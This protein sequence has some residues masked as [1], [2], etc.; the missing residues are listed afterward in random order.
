MFR[1][2][3]TIT[4]KYPVALVGAGPGSPDLLT[5]RAVETLRQ[6][7]LVIYDRLVPDQLL[8]YASSE[9]QFICVNHVH[10]EYQE[11]GPRINQV[12]IESAQ[13]G[14]RV[15]RLKGG[16]PFL[17]GRGGEEA[18][19]LHQAGI[20]FEV[21]PGVTAAL[22][23]AAYTGIPLTHRSHSSAVA[24]VTG[25]EQVGNPE[26]NLNWASLASFPG[27]LVF[28]MGLVRLPDIV[29]TLL[30]HNK[31]PRT[32][33]AAIQWATTSRQR[34]VTTPL[35]K[36]S[37]T[38]QSAGFESPT[39]VILG[40]VVELRS[41]LAWFENRPLFG[42][43]VLVTR[44]R[45]QAMELVQSLEERGAQV[46]V[47]PTIAILPPT[48][49]RPLDATLRTMD[50]VDWLIFT[51]ANGV[52]GFLDRLLQIGLDLRVLGKVQI[53][54]IG[55]A[56]ARCLQDYHLKPDLIPDSYRSESLVEK[57][58]DRAKGKRIVLARA[59]RGREVLLE[60][61]MQVATV[62]SVTVYCQQDLKLEKD[63]IGFL[64][65]GIDFITLTSSNIARSLLSQLDQSI[66]RS[67][68]SGKTK[69][70]SISPVTS[71]TI[72]GLGFPVAGEAR[73][74]TSSGLVEII[75]EMI[76]R[77]E[78]TV[79]PEMHRLPGTERLH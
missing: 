39:L 59:D 35:S 57:L 9:A 69:L 56:T 72:E 66:L 79:D 54:A 25:H 23:A 15:V 19:A 65:D 1:S 34:I 45:D 55:A 76:R 26:S 10:P 7:D 51:S 58:L 13:Q 60:Q 32:P 44:P 78:V 33:A 74:A 18:L 22:G 50:Q 12:L 27:T 36:L 49:F 11:R 37:E 41:E 73:E 16:D 61:L 71:S 43:R 8:R 68:T 2:A 4:Q 52:K 20:Q 62:H 14:L 6:A 75:C 42:R 17:F 70:I 46:F 5:L 47:L 31:D 53:A 77:E 21:I 48:D 3:S 38:V 40:P 24:F 63:Q 28:Y 30:Q 29:N 67:I 64:N